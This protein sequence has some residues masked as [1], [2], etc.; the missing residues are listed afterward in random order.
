MVK[1]IKQ[2]VFPYSDGWAVFEDRQPGMLRFFNAKEEAM[3]HA[4]ERSRYGETPV[5][6]HPS[7]PYQAQR[8]IS[9]I[10]PCIVSEEPLNAD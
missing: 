9:L 4:H 6:L 3:S 8:F 10:M 5:L 7:L 2:N 1:G